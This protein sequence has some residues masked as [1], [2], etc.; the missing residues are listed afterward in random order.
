MI[1]LS[2]VNND[3][4]I[5]YIEGLSEG[6]LFNSIKSKSKILIK[7]REYIWLTKWVNENITRNMI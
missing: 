1:G 3:Q 5:Y 4:F 6:H 7:Q 2:F